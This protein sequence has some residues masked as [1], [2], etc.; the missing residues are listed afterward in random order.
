MHFSYRGFEQHNG[1][2]QFTF[3]GLADK[4]PDRVFHFTVDLTLLTE[5]QVSIQ[6]TPSLCSE[7]LIK[8]LAEDSASMDTYCKYALSG[9]DLLAFTAPRRALA[10]SRGK[11]QWVRPK[12]SAASQPFTQAWGAPPAVS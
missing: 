9:A 12:P 11:K 6:E 7:L 3:L 2:R 8:A 5:H 10:A 1:T 4:Q